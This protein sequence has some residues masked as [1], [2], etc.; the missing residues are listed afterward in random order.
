[1]ILSS[2]SFFLGICSVALGY[3]LRGEPAAFSWIVLGFVFHG[4]LRKLI[5]TILGIE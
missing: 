5:E 3:W 2:I 4:F 1:M